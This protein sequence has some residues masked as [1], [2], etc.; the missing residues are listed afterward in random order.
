MIQIIPGPRRSGHKGLSTA[1]SLISLIRLFQDEDLS[2][3]EIQEKTGL[4]NNTVG[5]YIKLLHRAGA[6]CIYICEWRRDSTRGN[7]SR[8]YSWGWL[9]KDVQKP[10]PMTQKEYTRRWRLKLINKGCCY[11]SF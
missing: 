7:P 8:V 10:P 9:E 5:K 2:Y 11:I 4:A 1:S 3:T 6:N